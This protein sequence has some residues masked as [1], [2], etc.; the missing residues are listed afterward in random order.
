MFYNDYSHLTTTRIEPFYLVDNRTEPAHLFVPVKFTND[1]S[2]T[3]DGFEAALSWSI[4]SNVKTAFSYSYLNMALT[5]IDP[6]QEGADLISPEHQ[7]GTKIFWNI[8]E[9]I[10]VDTIILYTDEIAAFNLDNYVR[11]DINIGG[12]INK[13]LRF[14]L[15][16]Q[17]L[18]DGSHREFGAN[19]DLNVGEI[20]RSICAKL[21]WTFN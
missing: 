12:E 14:N 5:A 13:N 21:T 7:I 1:M 16:G 9:K 15:V 20:E 18:L 10:T 19:S 3:S 8:N 6:T 2:G 11:L 4:S 17:N